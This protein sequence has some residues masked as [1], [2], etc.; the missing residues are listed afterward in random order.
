MHTLL[1]FMLAGP[2]AAE[3]APSDR[4][5]AIATGLGAVAGPS[6][7]GGLSAGGSGFARLIAG[8]KALALDLGGRT[9][10]L[11]NDLREATTISAGLRWSPRIGERRLAYTR[12]GFVHNHET[13]WDALVADPLMSAIG[14]GEG[15]RHRSGGELALGARATLL[16][17]ETDGRWSGFA[18]LSVQGFPDDGGP[19]VYGGFDTGVAYAFGK[20]R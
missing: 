10:L 5:F 19:H 1:A 9:G 15:I 13:P 2:A 4:P 3:P 20:A 18:E 16:P 12:V 8:R 17:N 7:Q 11:A 14:S 6:T